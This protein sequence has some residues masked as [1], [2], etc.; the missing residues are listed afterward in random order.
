L[1]KYL[2]DSE[3]LRLFIIMIRLLKL[4]TRFNH[5]T[6]VLK[7]VIVANQTWLILLELIFNDEI[8]FL[9]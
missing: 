1:K 6:Y 7:K 2:L 4:H 3:V 8:I 9:C 5:T